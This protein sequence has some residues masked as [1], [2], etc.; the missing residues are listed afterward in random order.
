MPVLNSTRRDKATTFESLLARGVT[1]LQLDERAERRC[2]SCGQSFMGIFMA[3][4]QTVCPACVESNVRMTQ[5]ESRAAKLEERTRQMTAMGLEGKLLGMTFAAFVREEQPL[6]HDEAWQFFEQ[7]P[8]IQA[9]ALLGERG[10]G[11]THLATAI[12]LALSDGGIDG[13]YVHLPSLASDLAMAKDWQETASRLFVP[14]YKT[15]CLVIDDAGRERNRPDSAWAQML[16]TL[17]DR[18]S[19]GG[20]P[21]IVCA[22]LTRS[23]LVR[24]LGDAGAS[25]FMSVARLVDMTPGDR[26]F[27][28]PLGSTSLGSARDPLVACP[29]CQGAG[30]VLDAAFRA[31]N[32]DRL[33]K[34]RS[35]DGDGF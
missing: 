35:C 22:N 7:W 10:T 33:T 5:T 27:T 17:I 34:C 30:W 19:I 23:E 24:W 2:S 21:T 13:R 14:L 8:N 20:Y 4:I 1:T 26:R 15:S 18:R 16:D 6:A 32:P 28:R 25:R 29:S 31:G 12:L 11:K 3:E 9:L